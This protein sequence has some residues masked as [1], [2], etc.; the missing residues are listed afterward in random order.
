MW[1]TDPWTRINLRFLR[2]RCE[3]ARPE[4]Y[5]HPGSANRDRGSTNSLTGSTFEEY[6]ENGRRYCSPTYYMPN[7]DEEQTRLAVNHQAF[8]LILD[9]RL[10][11]SRIS[12]GVG[13]ILDVGTGLGDWAIAMSEKFPEA[14]IV[15][16]DISAFQPTEVPANVF[17][18]V[19]DAQE[20]W[21]Y[22]EP[23][24]FIHMRGLGGAFRDWPA[25]YAS[26]FKHL[27]SGGCFEITDIGLIS[28]KD[29]IPN[30]YLSI[31]NG[32]C[33]SAAE[34]AG[35]P[36]GLDYLKKSTIEPAGLSV[37]KSRV[38]EVPLGTW[39]PDRRRAAAGKMALVSA[40][41]G[42]EATSLRL[43]TRELDWTP[44]DVRDLCEKVKEEVM[45]PGVRAF[46]PCQI[47][48]AR[49]LFDHG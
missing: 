3:R 2:N 46:V 6:F 26:A 17:F 20:E 22:S 32:A 34:K 19:D 42:L 7:D 37:V 44:E 14:E 10:T 11:M 40:L 30:S 29:N 43:L 15:A 27:R 24:D 21:T 13:R 41:E 16:T 28:L 9:G 36:I 45:R 4:L 47:V 49:K 1:Q 31:F 8:L 33:Q 18:E 38:I 48:V 39:S 25:I 23:F 12:P 5:L 35:T